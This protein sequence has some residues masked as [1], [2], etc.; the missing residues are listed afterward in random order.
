MMMALFGSGQFSPQRGRRNDGLA[1]RSN[2]I[3]KA[4]RRRQVRGGR[5]ALIQIIDIAQFGHC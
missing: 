1:G 3:I 5:V 2:Y 4:G